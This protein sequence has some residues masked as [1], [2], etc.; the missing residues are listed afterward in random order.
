V[1]M[2]KRMK[3]K[4]FMLDELTTQLR[5]DSVAHYV[6]ADAPTAAKA[7]AAKPPAAKPTSGAGKSK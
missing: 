3:P 1:A 2:V 7:P 4:F 5:P 6:P